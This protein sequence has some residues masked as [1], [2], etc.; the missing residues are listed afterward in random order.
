M[1]SPDADHHA[2]HSRQ[3]HA[4]DERRQGAEATRDMGLHIM[5]HR[6]RF[7]SDYVPGTASR[8]APQTNR[9]AT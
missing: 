4:D 7:K 3:Y 6:C 9:M 2:Y 1:E 5:M 8:E